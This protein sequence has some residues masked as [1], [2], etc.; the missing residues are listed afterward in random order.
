MQST[1]ETYQF[2]LKPEDNQRLA[3]LCGQ[4]GDHIKIIEKHLG[5][6]IRNRGHRFEIEGAKNAIKAAA[7][8]LQKLYNDTKNNAD[9]TAQDVHMALQCAENGENLEQTKPVSLRTPN[10]AVTPKNLHQ[11]RYLVNMIS[12]DINFAIGPAGTGKTFLA[13]ACAAQALEKEEVRRII[14]VRP[15][16]EAGESL[17]YLPGDFAQKVEPYLRP[18]YDALYEL[19][20]FDW[21]NR[22]MERDQIEVA[23]LAYM[24]GRTLND[25]FIILDEA[26]NTTI[27]QMKMFLTRLGF[28]S[29]A[30][31]TGDITQ[32]DLPGKRASGLKHAMN[33]LQNVEGITFT[34][35]DAK[36]AVRH[37]LVQ[38]IIEAYA[39]T[40]KKWP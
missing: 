20:G 27:E 10:G 40:Q 28:G 32:I 34:H 35:F 17:G 36:D 13:V 5:I 16:V 15:A 23:P 39:S 1:A 3:N 11:Q 14:L 2:E 25:S 37:R 38:R 33:I 21:V 18:L 8:A 19:M 29:T 12:H 30:V 24:R 22:H 7:G 26:Q 9:L 4:L 31:I 6:K